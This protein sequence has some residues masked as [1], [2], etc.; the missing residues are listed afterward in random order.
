MKLETV[1]MHATR[2]WKDSTSIIFP[3]CKHRI[4][5]SKLKRL[6]LN[7]GV[8][9]SLDAVFFF[10]E[11]KKAFMWC[12]IVTPFS[13]T[14]STKFRYWTYRITLADTNV[15]V[16][17]ERLSH[18]GLSLATCCWGYDSC[19]AYKTLSPLS[20]PVAEFPAQHVHLL[21]MLLRWWWEPSFR[22][23]AKTD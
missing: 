8:G 2:D 3:T 13:I 16:G 4:L 23:S 11:G 5:I 15:G 6:F 14:F 19:Q 17:L 21:L 18:R 20:F 12:I 9:G 22:I 1:K 10:G 7:K